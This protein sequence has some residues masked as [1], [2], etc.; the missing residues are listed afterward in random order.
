MT[1][2]SE[3]G[4]RWAKVSDLTPGHGHKLLWDP[5]TGDEA[6]ADRNDY[7]NYPEDYEFTGFI[8]VRKVITYEPVEGKK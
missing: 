5:E 6:S 7:W 1:V 8:L 3:G 2:V 4:L